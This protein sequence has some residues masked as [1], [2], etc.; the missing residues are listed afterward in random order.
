MLV[1]DQRR[2]DGFQPNE[3]GRVSQGKKE[4]SARTRA[5][6][7]RPTTEYSERTPA[8]GATARRCSTVGHA[9]FRLKARVLR[10]RNHR[11]RTLHVRHM[12]PEVSPRYQALGN[13]PPLPSRLHR[14]EKGEESPPTAPCLGKVGCDG[15]IEPTVCTRRR[16]FAEL[17]ARIKG[18]RVPK[19]ALMGEL[20]VG[21]RCSGVQELD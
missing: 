12:E 17:T 9:P 6:G 13:R 11:E 19:T 14:M 15:C 16:Y 8:S 4:K 10:R 7:M 2:P 18:D 21:W 1:H 3:T 5:S 20:D